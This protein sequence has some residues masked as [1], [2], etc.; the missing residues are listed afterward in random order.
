[1]DQIPFE[2]N[3]LIL[4]LTWSFY[5]GLHSLFASNGVKN[6]FEKYFS[7]K[8]SMYRLIYSIA[9]VF[10]F[11]G[12]IYL[13]A[14]LEST[15]L[16]ESRASKALGMFVA[17]IGVVTISMSFRV[18]SGMEFL[19]LKKQKTELTLVTTGMHSKV[20]HPIYTGTILILIG[21]FLYHPT[22]IALVTD[23]IIFI[24]LPLGIYFEESKLIK[25]FGDEYLA[26]KKRVP[27]IIPN[28]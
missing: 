10:G 7:L 23:L 28:F 27:S 15:L 17:I 2:M 14:V 25:T 8:G 5:L 21:M 4:I 20:R 13:M 19:G 12:L 3:Y 9:S 16:F 22:D 11:L 24:Y 6:L 1:M 26:Y 18:L